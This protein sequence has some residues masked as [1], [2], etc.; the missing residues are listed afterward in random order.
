MFRTTFTLEAA[1]IQPWLDFVAQYLVH[2]AILAVAALTSIGMFLWGVR[3]IG[4]G[5]Q[6][7][8]GLAMVQI[9]LGWAVA[10]SAE[11]S[12]TGYPSTLFEAVVRPLADIPTGLIH[13]WDLKKASGFTAPATQF[14]LAA[15]VTEDFESVL[16]AAEAAAAR[17]FGSECIVGSV[18]EKLMEGDETTAKANLAN[19]SIEV[20]SVSTTCAAHATQIET[21]VTTWKGSRSRYAV[22]RAT[23]RE[24]ARG[25]VSAQEGG[26]G[27]A[28]EEI[29][30]LL[31]ATAP[32]EDE[33]DAG[34]AA[35]LVGENTGRVTAAFVAMP[36]LVQ[37]P[38][39]LVNVVLYVVAVAA[40]R[41]LTWYAYRAHQADQGCI[42][43]LTAA[44]TDANLHPLHSFAGYFVQAN[45]TDWAYAELYNGC[46]AKKAEIGRD[47]WAYRGFCILLLGF[48]LVYFNKRMAA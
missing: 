46:M 11:K 15:K 27:L 48:G 42:G 21:D 6:L 23:A 13:D 40:A 33:H 43:G 44:D 8:G 22:R 28:P 24:V 1:L 5:R 16:D 26:V 34:W 10:V 17:Q 32:V 39:G 36:A 45:A 2:G 12:G 31:E 37:L 18:L 25:V 20:G 30:G 19:R 7:M 3:R 35:R 38:A 4:E 29:R 9:L 47:T 14:P 41:G